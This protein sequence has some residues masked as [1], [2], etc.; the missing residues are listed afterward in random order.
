MIKVGQKVRFNPFHGVRQYGLGSV[1]DIV[2]GTVHYV[3]PTN[4]WFNVKYDNGDGTQLLGFKFHDIG[5]TVKL[6]K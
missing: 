1:H 3:H 2:D 5:K 6:V 4:G